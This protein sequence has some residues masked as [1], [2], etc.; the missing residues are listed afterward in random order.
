MTFS[1]GLNTVN[2]GSLTGFQQAVL[3]ILLI[4]GNIPFV[5]L[6]VVVVWMIYLRSGS[7]WR[8]RT[9]GRPLPPGSKSFP[10]VGNAF[11][12]PAHKPWIAYRGWSK[13]LYD[14]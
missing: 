5:S 3:C 10:V 2:L 8:I 4:I 7:T 11:N 1:T 6:F 12:A 14:G 13:N 9:R